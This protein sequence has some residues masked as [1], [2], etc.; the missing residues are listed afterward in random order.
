MSSQRKDSTPRRATAGVCLSLVLLFAASAWAVEE[1]PAPGYFL[2][3]LSKDS[4]WTEILAKPGIKVVFPYVAFGSTYVAISSVCVDGDA[5]AIADPRIDNGVRISAAELREQVQAANAGRDNLASAGSQLAAS[6]PIQPGS[7]V[8][9]HDPVKVYKL[10]ERGLLQD[11][12]FLFD[13][14]WPIQACPVH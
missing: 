2:D 7:N 1:Y 12:I 14:P 4:S 6:G 9:M 11:W 13:K 10:V 8:V 3:G 5:V